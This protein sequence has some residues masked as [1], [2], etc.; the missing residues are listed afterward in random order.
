MQIPKPTYMKSTNPACEKCSKYESTTF[1]F[2]RAKNNWDVVC[3]KCSVTGLYSIKASEFENPRQLGR[4]WRE[5][6][7]EKTWF[8]EPNF[9]SML[10][11][12][13]RGRHL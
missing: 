3:E 5:H 1:S 7:L 6:M 11:R 13:Y 8:Q 9:D 10:S 12:F 2:N 4:S